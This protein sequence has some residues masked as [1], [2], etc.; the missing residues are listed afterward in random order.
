M[1]VSVH[2]LAPRGQEENGWCGRT[3]PERLE[4]RSSFLDVG[5]SCRPRAPER[6]A[7]SIRTPHRAENR[8][9]THLGMSATNRCLCEAKRGAGKAGALG[10][11]LVA[12]SPSERP[13]S[14]TTH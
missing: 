11:D 14:S 7:C 12:N 10:L 8:C 1:G 5:F 13:S 2:E 9:E 4:A 3:L 6:F